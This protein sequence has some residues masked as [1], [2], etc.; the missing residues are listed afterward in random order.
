MMGKFR[1]LEFNELNEELISKSPPEIVLD[2]LAGYYRYHLSQNDQAKDYLIQRGLSQ[3]VID[4][5]EIGLSPGGFGQTVSQA[6]N[7]VWQSKVQSV[8]PRTMAAEQL[9]QQIMAILD[10]TGVTKNSENGSVFD[11]FR[12]RIVI[13]IKDQSGQVVSFGGRVFGDN[14][15][16]P[17]YLNGAD[18]PFFHKQQV[19]YGLDQVV[20]NHNVNAFTQPE[21]QVIE[22]YMDVISMHQFGYHTAVATMGTAINPQQIEMLFQYTN[23]LHFCFD[24]DEAGRKAA[25]RAVNNA[26]PC[27]YGAREVRV[28]FL[29]EGHDP[30][31]LLRQS[32]SSLVPTSED[33]KMGRMDLQHELDNSMSLEEYLVERYMSDLQ[34]T[35]EEEP[36]LLASSLIKDIV[37]MPQGSE[38]A[39]QLKDYVKIQLSSAGSEAMSEQSLITQFQTMMS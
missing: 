11:R 24:G 34:T 33:I 23:R 2:L 26:I 25:N 35:W 22:G 31:S 3:E 1:K 37:E 9:Q 18:S 36:A 39:S 32:C 20:K 8:L 7:K 10:I 13:P 4:K 28:T 38:S 5:F 19:I 16:G 27:M 12:G 17:K 15:Y 14:E 29:P 6:K 21:I 30:D